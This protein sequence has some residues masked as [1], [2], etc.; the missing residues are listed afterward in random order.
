MDY[1][2]HFLVIFGAPMPQPPPPP[3]IAQVR[4]DAILSALRDR[5]FRLALPTPGPAYCGMLLTS[6][7]GALQDGDTSLPLPAPCLTWTPLSADMALNLHAGTTG[8]FVLLGEDV[9]ALALG[10][11]AE[12]AELGRI[13]RLRANVPLDGARRVQDERLAALEVIRRE[14]RDPRHGSESLIEGHV[15]ALLVHLWRHASPDMA[16]IGGEAR[17]TRVLRRFRQLLE[18]HFRARWRIGRYA[19]A[20]GLSPDRLHDLCQRRLGKSPRQLVQ[21]RQMHEARLM[22]ERSTLTVDQV[23]AALGFADG[24]QFSRFFAARAG[25]PPGR[26]RKLTG[27]RSGTVPAAASYADWP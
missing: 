20:L 2:C 17:G 8:A 23:A 18:M 3:P 7:D 12:S 13:A 14:Q 1:D 4:A 27:E 6:G 5:T 26:Y 24:A 9:L 16:A 19:D 15:R 11:N 21:E 22:L 10:H 25:L